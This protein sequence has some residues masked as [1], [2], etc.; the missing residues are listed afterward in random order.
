M[1][2]YAHTYIH[3]AGT[4]A[5]KATPSM[6]SIVHTHIHTYTHT[7]IHIYTH[8]HIHTYTHAHIHIYTLT[9]I[10]IY[11]HTHIHTHT[12]THIHIYT[13][14]HEYVS[15]YTFI[16]WRICV[17]IMAQVHLP[18]KQYSAWPPPKLLRGRTLWRLA[19]EWRPL[20]LSLAWRKQVCAAKQRKQ[21]RV[22]VCVCERE[23]LCVSGS[24]VCVGGVCCR[25]FVC[26]GL[27]QNMLCCG[28][29]KIHTQGIA[30]AW[31]CE[32]VSMRECVAVWG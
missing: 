26:C 29:A 8:T 15:M 27:L 5:T 10:H 6:T 32:R 25:P 20:V 19:P 23:K 12:Y 18:Q 21:G 30:Y 28:A 13:Y 9:H 16:Y 22:C 4:P 3:S 17:C 1:Y 31:E 2:T 11:T 7:H 14:T 24:W